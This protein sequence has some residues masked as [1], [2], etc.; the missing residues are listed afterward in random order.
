[1]SFVQLT[2]A[3]MQA[4]QS[5]TT[6]T[7]RPRPELRRLKRKL[8]DF[9]FY[10]DTDLLELQSGLMSLL[11]GLWVLN[12]WTDA[13]RRLV[14]YHAVAS[15]LPEWLLGSLVVT[16]GLLQLV[17]L[18]AHGIVARRAGNMLSIFLWLF[19]SALA[20]TGSEPSPSLILFVSMAVTSLL[21]YV[22]TGCYHT[23]KI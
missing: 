17:G 1:M 3:T 4:T 7:A 19:V 8:T 16:A 2:Q 14:G 22:R 18:F 10:S 15:W 9:M 6:L 11:W 20:C 5:D 13:L 12:P 23:V 21:V